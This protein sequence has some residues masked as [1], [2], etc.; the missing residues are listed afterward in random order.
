VNIDIYEDS[1][2]EKQQIVATIGPDVEGGLILS[3]HI[4]TVPFAEQPGWELDPLKLVHKEGRIYGRGSC[5]MKLFIAQ[6]LYACSLSDLS[7]LKKPLVLVFT[8]D[9]E[10]GCHGSAR[11][12]DSMDRLLGKIPRPR[13]AVIGEPTS[14]EIVDTHKGMGHFELVLKGKA[15]HSSRPD[16]GSNATHK[17]SYVLE[18][19]EKLNRSYEKEINDQMRKTFPDFPRNY[20]HLAQIRSGEA[21]NMVPDKAVLGFSFRSFPFDK[22]LRVLEDFQEILAQKLDAGSYEILGAFSAPPMR[23]AEDPE[24]L[25]ALKACCDSSD[26]KSVSFA[27]DGGNFSEMGIETYIWGPGEIKM[28]HR[29]NEYMPESDFYRGPKMIQQLIEKVLF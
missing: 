3:G 24:L 27:T 14:F 22:P 2:V 7:K 29:P 20:L 19:V 21:L 1:G 26:T 9:E 5:D 4:D 17:I 13:R 12:I 15:W 11:L 6:C 23:K 28:A 18:A 25:S 16:L 10:T 8:S